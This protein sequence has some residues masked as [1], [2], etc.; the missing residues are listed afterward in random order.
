MYSYP[1]LRTLNNP[2]R[3]CGTVKQW[4]KYVTT[5][6][7]TTARSSPSFTVMIAFVKHGSELYCVQLNEL[8]DNSLPQTARAAAPSHTRQLLLGP[9]LPLSWSMQCEAPK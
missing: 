3:G 4:Q 6:G 2:K 7:A 1:Y 9:N 8:D 5:I